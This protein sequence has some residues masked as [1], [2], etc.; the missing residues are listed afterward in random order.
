MKRWCLSGKRVLPDKCC[1]GKQQ[2]PPLNLMKRRL[3]LS[4]LCVLATASVWAAG[5]FSTL[6]VEL[7]GGTSLHYMLIQFPQLTL[8]GEELT[9]RV[10][11]VTYP[12]P[13][14]PD[15]EQGAVNPEAT[16]TTYQVEQVEKFYF[17]MYDPNAIEE[18]LV[19][20]KPTVWIKQMDGQSV[21][22]S[23]T[24][25]SDRIR[26]FT[27]DGRMVQSAVSSDEGETTLAIGTLGKGIYIIQVNEKVSFKIM[28]Q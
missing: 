28:K 14:N 4:V 23:G 2:D 11:E 27:T 18:P 24:E 16:S 1:K 19:E 17:K 15:P 22:I 25:A 13:A 12:D 6:V 7:K 21:T 26:I 20:Q 5:E 9:I 3:L 8:K 10:H